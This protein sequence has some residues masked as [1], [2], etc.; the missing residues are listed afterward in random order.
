VRI[1]TDMTEVV[2]LFFDYSYGIFKLFLIVD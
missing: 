2:S 1:S